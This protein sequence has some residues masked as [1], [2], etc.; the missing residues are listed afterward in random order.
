MRTFSGRSGDGHRFRRGKLP[1]LRQVPQSAH[2]RAEQN[3]QRFR[4]TCT[5]RPDTP[6]GT[7]QDFFRS[8]DSSLP[9]GSVPHPTPIFG[10]EGHFLPQGLRFRRRPFLTEAPG[11]I[12]SCA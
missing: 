5:W 12:L 3:L 7:G 10:G 9:D 6:T 8:H 4:D 1:R 11:S 2:S